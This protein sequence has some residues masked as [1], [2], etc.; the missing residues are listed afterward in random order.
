[1]SSAMLFLPRLNDSKYTES[2]PE[3]YGG[4]ARAT[5]P[6]TEGSSILI[7]S[8]PRSASWSVPHGPAP[9][10]SIAITRTSASGCTRHFHQPVGVLELEDVEDEVLCACVDVLADARDALLGRPG[11]AVAV[12]DVLREIPRVPRT[13]VLVERERV[14][15]VRRQRDRRRH[16]PGQLREPGPEPLRRDP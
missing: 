8:A 15:D 12:D 6:P 3:M 11:D 5:S 1:M 9:N 14:A 10:C 4:I 2:E 13:Q 16:V 7:T